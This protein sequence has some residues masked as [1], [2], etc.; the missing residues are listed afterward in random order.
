MS[1]FESTLPFGEPELMRVSSFRRYLADMHRRGGGDTTGVTTRLSSL[2]P[3]LME[4][5]LRFEHGGRGADV[6]EVMA[7]SVRHARSLT[8]HLQHGTRVVPLTVFPR[9]RLAHCPLDLQVVVEGQSPDLPVLQVEAAV[10][11]PLGDRETELIGE[12]QLY[13]PLSPLMWALALHGRRG[14]LL[15]EVAGTAVYRVSPAFDVTLAPDGPMRDTLRHLR[16]T[17]ASLRDIAEW[18]GFDRDKACRLI[19]ALYL[20]SGLIISRSH[21]AALGDSSW[22]GGAGSA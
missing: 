1:H 19:N 21:P 16:R 20:Q 13:R 14:E 11:K 15:P 8:A 9:E 18:P 10:L 5:L 7:A 4:D 3:S 12:P 6:L 2:N 22:F 17:V